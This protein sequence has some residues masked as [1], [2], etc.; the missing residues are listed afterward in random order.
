[1]VSPALIAAVMIGALTPP[2]SF[3]GMEPADPLAR[4]NKLQRQYEES[5]AAYEKSQSTANTKYFVE[6][7]VRYATAVMTSPHIPA[8]E[9]YPKALNLYREAQK[10]DPEN[11]EAK[12]NITLIE[13]IYESLGRSVPE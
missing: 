2:P 9:K 1:M 6:D 4:V 11:A 7:T 10:A 8:K 3:G 13:G 5:K 12:E